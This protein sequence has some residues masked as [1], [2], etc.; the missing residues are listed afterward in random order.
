VRA[1]VEMLLRARAEMGPFHEAPRPALEATVDDPVSERPGA[2]IGAGRS[3][4]QYGTV[5][6]RTGWAICA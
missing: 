4:R 1:E 6:C 2:V 3:S 5:R